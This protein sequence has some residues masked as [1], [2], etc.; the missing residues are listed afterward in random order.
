[1][2]EIIHLRH[3]WA[4]GDTVC[5]SALV[6]DLVL[7]YPDKFRLFISGPYV[8]FW[9]NNPYVSSA[10]PTAEDI[11]GARLVNLKYEDGIRAASRGERVHFLAWFHRDFQRHTGIAVPVH[12]PK[13]DIHLS[14]EER[15]P[16]VGGR[17]WIVMAGGKNDMTTK[18]YPEARWQA[19]VDGLYKAGVRLVQAGANFNRHFNPCLRN[20][21]SA[22]G[23]TDDIRDLFSLIY[24]AEG[25]ICGITSGMHIAAAFDKPCVVIAGGREE[26]WWEAYVNDYG[27]FGPN[28]T[29]VRVPHRFLHTIDKLHCCLDRGCWKKKTVRIDPRDKEQDLCKE[30]VRG[31]GDVLP[32]CL[33]MIPPEQVVDEVLSY[34]RDGTLAPLPGAARQPPPVIALPGFELPSIASIAPSAPPEELRFVRYLPVAQPVATV[35]R[36]TEVTPPAGTDPM[37]GVLDH[38]LLGGKFTL[39]VLCYGPHTDL[40]KRCLTSILGSVPRERLDLRLA[41]NAAAPETLSY[42]ASLQPTKVYV[43]SENRMKYPVM[44]EM[45]WDPTCPIQSPYVIWFDDD[46]FV[47]DGKWIL[48][49]AETIVANHKEGCRL[50]GAKFFHDLTMFA[51]NGHDPRNWFRSARWWRG[52]DF[53]LKGR[54]SGAPNGSSINFVAGGFWALATHIIREGNIPD[55]RLHHNGGDITIGETVKQTGYRIKVFNEKKQFVHTSG[56]PRRGHHESF[57]WSRPSS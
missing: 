20:V 17:Y 35:R 25:V 13:G 5:V 56:A 3:T 12:Y 32:R 22:V 48:R 19:V 52:K 57:P 1:M 15:R 6:R 28:C 53:C 4:L 42:L 54:D 33:E 11:S 39:F 27:A 44:R 16:L 29:P 49:L 47:V 40:A 23:A 46:S 34:Y 7:S 8:S 50:Y 30:P 14:D 31:R 10:K 51:R 21:L 37:F 18:W 9:K 36:P 45:F 2:P 43:N 41:T 26:P 38:P 55:E 24:H